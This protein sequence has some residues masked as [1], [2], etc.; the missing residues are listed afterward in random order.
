MTTFTTLFLRTEAFWGQGVA[1]ADAFSAFHCS[2]CNAALDCVQQGTLRRKITAI[3]SEN[4]ASVLPAPARSAL[5]RRLA[6]SS[7][8]QSAGG[9]PGGTDLCHASKGNLVLEHLQDL[10]S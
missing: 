4:C 8:Q 6:P 2:V 5:C 3:P 7:V 10:C 9:C 1:A